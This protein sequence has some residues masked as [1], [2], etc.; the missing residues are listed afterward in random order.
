VRGTAQIAA[1]VLP[2]ILSGVGHGSHLCAFYE[3]K[4][5][6]IDLVLPFFDAGLNQGELCVWMMPDYVSAKEAAAIAAERRVELYPGRALYTKGPRFERGPIVSFWNEKLQQALATNCS[7]LHASGD[8]FWL[9]PTEWSA[10]LDYEA[11]LTNMIAD[12]PITL[13]CTYPLMV[14]KAGDLADVARVHHVAIAKRKTDWEVIKGWGTGGAPGTDQLRRVEAWDAATR[15]LSLSQRERQ[16]LDAVV[17]GHS[18]KTIA[19]ELG[20]S[21]RTVEAHRTRL[22]DRLEV[23]T[24]VEAVRLTTLSRLILPA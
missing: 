12:K 10:F 20:I 23:R 4:D 14:S 3:T 11:D 6:L 17:E 7:G 24:T 21:V 5:D 9:Q 18:N 1:K 16:V 2:A 8:A 15:I 19:R 13:L 22:L